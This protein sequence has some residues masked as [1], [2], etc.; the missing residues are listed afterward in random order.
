RPS[1]FRGR[2]LVGLVGPGESGF[3]FLFANRLWRAWA[4]LACG[5]HLEHQGCFRLSELQG[6]AQGIALRRDEVTLRLVCKPRLDMRRKSADHRKALRPG[7]NQP[8]RQGID[9]MRR[10]RN[11]L[12][13]DRISVHRV[14]DDQRREFSEIARLCMGDPA[15]DSMWVRLEF[16]EQRAQ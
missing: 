16:G 12:A 6:A 5:K 13:R 4:E 10:K 11:K 8:R 15:H 7:S 3:L 1:A 14:L 2:S 9:V